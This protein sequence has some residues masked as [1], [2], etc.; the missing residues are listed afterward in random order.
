MVLP[1]SSLS[2]IPISCLVTPSQRS[3]VR[4]VVLSLLLL[5]LLQV[6]VIATKVF[7]LVR[8]GVRFV[9]MPRMLWAAAEFGACTAANYG[10]FLGRQQ[11]SYGRDVFPFLSSSARPAGQSSPKASSSPSGQP[12]MGTTSSFFIFGRQQES[13]GREVF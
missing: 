6:V 13:Y 9:G 3:S 12:P 5:D 8:P 7:W 10:F 2:E 4:D 1:R 11:E